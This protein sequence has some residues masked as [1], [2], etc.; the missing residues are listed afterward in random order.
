LNPDTSSDWPLVRSK[1]VR[2][3]SANVEINLI[4]ASGHVEI[5]SQICS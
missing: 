3:V 4:I 1:G 5:I 2:F